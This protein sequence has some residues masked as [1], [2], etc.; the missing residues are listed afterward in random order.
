MGD[1]KSIFKIR[2][3]LFFYDVVIFAIS[4]LLLL[5]LYRGNENLT[6]QGVIQQ[7]LLSSVCVFAFRLVGNVYRQIW[8]YGGI[9]CYIRLLFTDALA[10]LLYVTLEMFLPVEHVTFARMLSLISINL[11]GALSIRMVYRY[12]IK[13]CN[14][15]TFLG[16]LLTAML[17]IFAGI[18]HVNEN[19]TQK[20]K[21]AIIGA[22]SV[23]VSLA[24]ELLTNKESAYVPRCFIDSDK[25]KVGR[26]IQGIP[27]FAED[28]VTLEKMR[29]HE[30][31]EIIF[32]VT[33]MDENTRKE[34]YETYKKYGFSINVYDY[35]SM[36][37]AGRKRHLREFT[38]EELLFRKPVE[39]S[40]KY[41]NDYYRNKV[42]L[43]TG[44]GGSI[45]SE[46]CRQ[47]SRMSPKQLII[48]DI[49]EN[50]A[51]DVQ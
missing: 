28:E 24:K 15:D 33:S 30:I 36:H 9:Q 4:S 35:P 2:W 8:R 1:K 37:T 13:C 16:K 14:K 19:D 48:L 20:I 26:E 22:G 12:A 41:T 47:I 31:Q 42:V 10:F 39:L 6:V 3:M 45:G 18:D 38:I 49:Y 34:L 11:L 5:V 29:K 27:V 46:L 43:I 23:G 50:G 17:H 21:V 51:Y 44:G 7:V 25:T 32:A 40:D